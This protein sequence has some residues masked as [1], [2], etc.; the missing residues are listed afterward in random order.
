MQVRISCIKISFELGKTQCPAYQLWSSCL[1]SYWVCIQPLIFFPYKITFICC[2]C[3][4]DYIEMRPVF[5][6]GINQ[7]NSLWDI[8]RHSYKV[9]WKQYVI[10][11]IL[12][13]KF[14]TNPL[15]IKMNFQLFKFMLLPLQKPLFLE[16]SHFSSLS[17]RALIHYLS[18]NWTAP[19]RPHYENSFISTH[20]P[21]GDEREWKEEKDVVWVSNREKEKG[22]ENVCM[23]C[24]IY[25]YLIVR[26]N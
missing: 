2:L 20:L 7:L 22:N 8:S 4:E 3:L 11:P 1:K 26:Q 13:K 10:D 23:L 18:P 19:F 6:F 12:F 25:H 21:S 15:L 16:I 9:R 5:S 14:F 24:Y 17:S